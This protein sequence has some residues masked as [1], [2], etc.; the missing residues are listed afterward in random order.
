[1]SKRA[2]YFVI[3]A[4]C[5]AAVNAFADFDG[6]GATFVDKALEPQV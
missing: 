5:V 1:M 4:A 6:D 2:S 3:L